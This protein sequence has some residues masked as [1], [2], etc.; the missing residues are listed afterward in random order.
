MG[1]FVSWLMRCQD[2]ANSSIIADMQLDHVVIL[3]DDLESSSA[4]YRQRGFNVVQGGEHKAFG[5]H[6]AL[7]PF[8][9]GSYLELAAFRESTPIQG[10]SAEYQRR[11]AAG[12]SRLSARWLS[13]NGLPTGLID[14]ALIPDNLDE[15]QQCGIDIETQTMGRA[16]PDGVELAWKMGHAATLDL[17]FLIEDI[18]PRDW[19]VPDATN[20]PNGV[21]GIVEIEVVV[22]EIP[23]SRANYQQLLQQKGVQSDQS[24]TFQC[25]NTKII[26]AP[27]DT[28]QRHHHLTE[29]GA[30]PYNFTLK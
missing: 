17:P 5:S 11:L 16:R 27:P 23:K 1:V 18:T 25:G 12:E 13:M 4:D 21:Q 26:L 22:P 3:V 19:R 28:P 2:C 6:N 30:S 29:R 8:V 14:F 20:H 7:I 9:D 15:V 10:R 24:V